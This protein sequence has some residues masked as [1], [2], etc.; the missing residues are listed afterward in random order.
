M[1]PIV[2]VS[3]PIGVGAIS[4]V[5]MS[6]DGCINIANK[7]V[8]CKEKIEP[9]RVI[10]G[11]FHFNNNNE[12]CLLVYF[13]APHSY[14]GEDIVEF[15]CH[16]GEF[17][18]KEVLNALIKNGASLAENG[19]FTK[20][21]FLNGKVSLD[22]AEGIIDVI[23]AG[24]EAEL[25]AGYNLMSGKLLTEVKTLQ[26]SIVDAIANLD[27]TLDYPE[28]DDEAETLLTTKKTISDVLKK[29]SELLSTSS[30]GKLIKNGIT[31]AIVGK[32]NVGKSSLLNA[33]LGEERAIV[34]DIE[35]T[36]RDTITETIIYKN[37]KI[38]FIDTAGVRES[39]NI[40]EKI[41]IDRSYRS[42]NS[43][44]IVLV[45]LDSSSELTED[46][47]KL[48][49]LT[50]DKKR[51]IILNKMD[52]QKKLDINEKYILISA[53]DG[54]NIEQVKEEIFN[55][56][57]GGN[58]DISGLILTNVRHIEAL[59]KAKEIAEKALD[60]CDNS[61]TDI[62]S[63]L[64]KELWAELGKITGETETESIIDAI[65]SKFC[66]GK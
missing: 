40:V 59:S 64:L 2:A 55:S 7:V 25:K 31:V 65:F 46:D 23:N 54:K 10:L 1:K 51:I 47:K 29:L 18:T 52:K 44:D 3:T 15:Q 45:V 35:G 36:T 13:K 16:G 17:L 22:S 57:D 4:I 21:A 61:T 56:F 38:N 11:T 63:F 9:S 6:G 26:S 42:I 66:L 48:L 27:M 5:R 12:K 50:K 53:K 8:S 43:A 60:S 37:I 28:H 30:A 49:D 58:I 41:G 20:R 62:I 14:T 32:P 39:D 33:L 24:T 34:T 19:E